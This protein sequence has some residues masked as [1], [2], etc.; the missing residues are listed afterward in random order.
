[1]SALL[2][3]RLTRSQLPASMGDVYPRAVASKPWWWT[4][5]DCIVVD[6]ATPDDAAA[7]LLPSELSLLPA[8]RS[9]QAIARL[10]LATYGGGTLG[11]YREAIVEIGCLYEESFAL[12]TPYAY[13]D[14]IPALASGREVTGFPRQ[15]GTIAVQCAGLGFSA[16]L[17]QH[18]RRLFS[19]HGTMGEPLTSLPLSRTSRPVLPPPFDRTLPLPEPDG[20]RHGIAIPVITTRFIPWGI[21]PQ[22][23]LSEW[24]WEKGT[25]CAAEAAV[26]HHPA[27]IGPLAKLPVV[28]VLGALVL[29][30][31]LTLHGS[32]IL[33]DMA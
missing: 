21:E 15:F 8:E 23:I 16:H 4:D 10:W 31:D 26:G 13:V 33:Q 24:A 3:G 17:D 14:S 19:V 25:A 9:G 5:A 18:G 20:D 6:Y 27:D 2:P 1:V 12:Y 29:R 22:H 7:A 30:G 28:E 32:T 11:P